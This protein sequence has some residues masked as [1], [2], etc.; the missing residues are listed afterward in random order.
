[1][2]DFFG[3]KSIQIEPCEIMAFGIR[4]S[5]RYG[6][7]D[8]IIE[9]I[10]FAKSAAMCDV[11]YCVKA[12][13]YDSQSQCCFFTLAPSVDPYGELAG[14]IHSVAEKTI[15]QFDL[16]NMVYYGADLLA[17]ENKKLRSS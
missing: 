8:E 6:K 4:L 5:S 2:K 16:F 1:M 10:K 9:M 15:R 7:A 12:V 11:A 17:E 3:E 13:S 14:K